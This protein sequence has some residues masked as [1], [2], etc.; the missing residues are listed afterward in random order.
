MEYLVIGFI[1]MISAMLLFFRVIEP[2]YI[3][4]YNKPLYIHFY[5]F[6]K[7]L[8]KPQKEI[9]QSEFMFYKKLSPKEKKYF[10]YRVANFISEYDFIAKEGLVLTDQMKVLIAATST[11][12]TF[13]MKNY[14]FNVFQRVIIYPE[15]YYSTIEEVYHKGEF[16]PRMRT[17]VFSWK[18]FLEGYRIDN[19]NHNLGLH[20]F[21][22][23]LNFQALKSNDTS[24]IIFKDMYKEIMEYIH[25]SQTANRFLESDYFRIYAYTNKFEFIAVILEHFFETPQQF[26]SEFPELYHKVE[27]M[28]NYKES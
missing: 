3:A 14:L 13:G 19:D 18:H 11:M 25:Q 17:L 12:L 4:L 8:S 23:V 9:L 20:E 5:L 1:I 24:M 2:G 16:N 15:E 28:I 7:K 6:P 22:H 27:L 26:K 21:A 10:E